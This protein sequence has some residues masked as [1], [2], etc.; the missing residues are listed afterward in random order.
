MKI[1][2]EPRPFNPYAVTSSGEDLSG[3]DKFLGVAE[4]GLEFHDRLVVRPEYGVYAIFD[5]MGGYR[6][7]AGPAAE[8]AAE[9]CYNAYQN[10][11]AGFGR[12]RLS[13]IS[14]LEAWLK[15]TDKKIRELESGT[16]AVAMRMIEEE[17]RP[18]IVYA[19]VGDSRLYLF[20]NGEVNQISVDEGYADRV[21]N[22]L[23]IGNVAIRQIGS[24]GLREGDRLMLCSDGITGDRGRDVLSEEELAEALRIQPP[25]AAA[26]YLLRISRKIDDKSVIVVD[27]D[28][29]SRES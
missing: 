20:R 16:T 10:L 18:Y 6:D 24:I 23:G 14:R 17:G 12:Q 11:P 25:Q 26:D 27:V 13:E 21:S 29:N 3:L 28:L 19:S 22:C 9:A 15:A 2:D 5:G 7:K 8:A 4:R 1:Y